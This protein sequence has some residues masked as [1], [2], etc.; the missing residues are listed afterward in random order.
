VVAAVISGSMFLLHRVLRALDVGREAVTGHALILTWLLG[1]VI[2]KIGLFIASSYLSF[3][4]YKI[5]KPPE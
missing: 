2:W 5:L 3:T 4:E 1:L